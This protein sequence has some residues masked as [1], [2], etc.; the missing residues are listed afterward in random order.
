MKLFYEYTNQHN[1]VG[2]NIKAISKFCHKLT[3][4]KTRLNQD[5][6]EVDEYSLCMEIVMLYISLFHYIFIDHMNTKRF[7][8]EV[9]PPDR[10]HRYGYQCDYTAKI[11][12][13]ESIIEK[14]NWGQYWMSTLLCLK[15][16]FD[17]NSYPNDA[18]TVKQLVDNGNILSK[19][20]L[21]NLRFIS[22]G[23]QCLPS[24]LF[25]PKKKHF[26]T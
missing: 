19:K 9:L 26:C 2:Y 5:F 17:D 7:F 8:N 25:W 10:W 24:L 11:H 15:R 18:Q 21:L 6:C 16:V 12:S 13:L 14:S 3:P 23:Y 1:T 22:V 20:R 4:N